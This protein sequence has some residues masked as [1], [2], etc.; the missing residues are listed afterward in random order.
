MV[1]ANAYGHNAVQL[2]PVICDVCD[3]FAVA[4]LSE[5]VKIKPFAGATDI[6]ILLPVPIKSIDEVLKSDFICSVSA[7]SE[8]IELEK[9]C[10]A[11]DKTLRIHL[12]FD[13]GMNRLGFKIDNCKD[14]L[15]ALQDCKHLKLCGIYTHF[16]DTEALYLKSCSESFERA[17]IQFQAVYP[18]MKSHACASSTLL[19]KKINRYDMARCGILMYGYGKDV[20]PAMEVYSA[21]I[22]VKNVKQGESIGYN[23][24]YQASKEMQIAVI[25]CGYADGYPRSLSNCGKVLIKNRVCPVVGNVCMDLLMA[26]VTGLVCQSG[27]EV[28]LMSS[29]NQI[30]EISFEYN[31][32]AAETIVYEL[33]TGFDRERNTREYKYQ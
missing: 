23:R 12:K 18:K 20:T 17:L 14:L 4:T 19:D 15:N 3:L 10:S 11:K 27:D 13:S 5:A 16:C 30:E 24:T 7:V 29:L 25:S 32:A 9:I 6:L 1:K 22:L 2:C 21:V 28:V 26:D 8:L 33:L 31:A